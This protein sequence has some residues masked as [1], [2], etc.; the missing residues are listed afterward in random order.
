VS[1]LGPEWIRLD[2]VPKSKLT[3]REKM[4]ALAIAMEDAALV[5]SLQLIHGREAGM[6]MYQERLGRVMP[7]ARGNACICI[8]AVRVAA[9]GGLGD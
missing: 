4:A 7:D 3:D 8:P 9:R 6:A 5:E 2:K 1:G